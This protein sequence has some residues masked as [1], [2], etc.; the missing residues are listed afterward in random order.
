MN[1]AENQEDA[2]LYA[3]SGYVRNCPKAADVWCKYLVFNN[4]AICSAARELII[5]EVYVPDDLLLCQR[6]FVIESN[7]HY[8]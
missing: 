8:I 1:V 6:E 4:L 7:N 3:A 5:C 2:E